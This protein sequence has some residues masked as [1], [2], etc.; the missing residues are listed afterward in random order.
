M[1]FNEQLFD[2]TRKAI[3]NITTRSIS[4]Y[5]GK[6]DGY[7]SSMTSQGS[8]ITTDALLSFA[9]VLDFIRN[10]SPN[11]QLTE[12]ISFVENE[13][14]HRMT[15]IDMPNYR[16]RKSILAAVSRINYNAAPLA[17]LPV[18]VGF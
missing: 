4:R 8:A 2:K 10:E 16:V 14:A 3:P 1:N 12:L 9:S 13:V 17:P 5:M 15:Y 11:K 7:W 6:S 18:L